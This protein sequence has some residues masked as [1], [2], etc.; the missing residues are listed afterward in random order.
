VING[1]AVG[2]GL[3]MTLPMDV[4]LAAEGARFGAVFT[5]RGIVPEAAS[6]WFLPRIVGPSR[7]AEWLYTGRLF[8]AGEALAAGLVR[9]VHPADELMPAAVA[10]AREMA[11][12]TA[13]VSVALT[14]QLIWRGL[15][16]DE[17][18]SSHLADSRGMAVMGAGP[19]AREGVTA[20]LEKRAP[21]FPGR[22]ST[23]LPDVFSDPQPD[24]A[25]QLPWVRPRSGPA[26]QDGPGAGAST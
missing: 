3:T 17:P 25:A 16:F 12:G 8:D 21:S 6:T 2:V 10:L 26:Q 24:W 13:P 20:F 15:T 23:D 4:R 5:R 18:Y 11:D 14:R 9:S 22:V 7:A 1:A 19:D